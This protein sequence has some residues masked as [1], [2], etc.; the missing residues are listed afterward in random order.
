MLGVIVWA[1]VFGAVGYLVSRNDFRTQSFYDF[2]RVL[3]PVIAM[4]AIHAY[5]RV[6][7]APGN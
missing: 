2:F 7:N 3:L 1:F 6:W 5:E 4:V